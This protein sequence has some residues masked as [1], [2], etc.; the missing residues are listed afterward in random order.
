MQHQVKRKPKQWEVTR[1]W[2]RKRLGRNG[3]DSRMSVF[4]HISILQMFI[5]ILQLLG[6][7]NRVVVFLLSPAYPIPTKQNNYY[8]EG[9]TLA[10]NGI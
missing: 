8:G 9:V 6:T 2:D 3:S 7:F 5:C 4:S 10:V 1:Q